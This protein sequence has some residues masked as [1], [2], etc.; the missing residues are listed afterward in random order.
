MSLIY[1]SFV[2]LLVES[3]TAM[4]K[5]DEFHP[6]RQW[7]DEAVSMRTAERQHGEGMT[8]SGPRI[9]SRRQTVDRKFASVLQGGAGSPQRGRAATL[10][11]VIIIRI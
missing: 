10:L 9:Q 7:R 3:K 4:S 2:F 11:H 6:S 5:V 8:P 1:L